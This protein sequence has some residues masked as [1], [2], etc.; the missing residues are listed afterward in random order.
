MRVQPIL[1]W[2]GPPLPSILY[3][4]QGQAYELVQEAMTDFPPQPD[5]TQRS[6]IVRLLL[7][8]WNIQGSPSFPRGWAREVMLGLHN[9]GC[10]VP[11][12]KVLRWYRSGL[13]VDP[14]QF[15]SVP[16]IPK[17][18]LVDLITSNWA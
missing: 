7:A 2:T 12:S 5:Q 6:N 13:A 10:A 15:K 16:H 11:T 18:M 1:D 3:A 8:M 9:H 17:E 4:T 14:G